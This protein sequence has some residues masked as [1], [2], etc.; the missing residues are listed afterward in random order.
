MTLLAPPPVPATLDLRHFKD[1]PLEVRR[2][3][4]S[5]IIGIGDAE[6]F[7]CNFSLW[8]G[9]WHQVP[10]GSVP[11][12]DAT[13]A[14]MAGLGR[15]I[16]TWQRIKDGALHGFRKFGDGRWYHRVVCEKAVESWNSSA[17]FVWKRECDRLRKENDD[18]KK[19]N[20][21]ELQKPP[22]PERVSMA[23]P[24]DGADPVDDPSEQPRKSIEADAGK[25]P[26]SDKNSTG[27]SD[28]IPTEN[29]GREGKGVE[30]KEARKNSEANASAASAGKFDQAS[31]DPK[32]VL[33]GPACRSYVSQRIGK[34]DA[35]ARALIGRWCRDFGQD[36]GALLAALGAT[37]D[38]PPGNLIE[39]MAGIVR[40]RKANGLPTTV[41]E[42]YAQRDNDPIWKGVL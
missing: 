29:A 20:L 13:L 30:K 25:E 38:N 2:V 8:C 7:R 40:H 33:F 10:A 34:N 18:R 36:A 9:S 24:M 4:D 32:A 16:K 1:M 37:Q 35:A 14:R 23:W 41:E 5:D 17:V 6:I 19:A 26:V 22:K 15:D 39:W 31:A 11:D 3:R 42:A 27:R 12:D 28:G 21:P